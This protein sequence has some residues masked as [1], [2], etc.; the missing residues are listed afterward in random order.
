M[1][2]KEIGGKKVKE[3]PSLRTIEVEH[4]ASIQRLNSTKVNS[5]EGNQLRKINLGNP[6]NSG[7]A[8]NS[9]G[10]SPDFLRYPVNVNDNKS[11]SVQ[12]SDVSDNVLAHGYLLSP[13]IESPKKNSQRVPL[14]IHYIPNPTGD[15]RN[16]PLQN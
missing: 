16:K 14:K 3:N 13:S 12:L 1:Q 7:G 5:R 2:D 8:D 15:N 4:E 6:M 9:P 11:N 10:K